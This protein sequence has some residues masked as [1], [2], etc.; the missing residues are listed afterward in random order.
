MSPDQAEFLKVIGAIFMGVFGFTFV[1]CL[2][3]ALIN[4]SERSFKLAKI[5]AIVAAGALLFVF[6]AIAMIF[7]SLA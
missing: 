5:C 1:G 2:I 4:Y 3:A 7:F 6:A